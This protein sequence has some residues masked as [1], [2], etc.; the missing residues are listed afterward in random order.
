M[1]TCACPCT[2]QG[3]SRVKQNRASKRARAALSG[4][5]AAPK[6]ARTALSSAQAAPKQARTALSSA[7]ASPKRARGGNFERPGGAEQ[8]RAAI[9]S[10]PVA[11]VQEI[12]RF[13][14]RQ[15]ARMSGKAPGN[16]KTS[17]APARK[18]TYRY[19]YIYIYIYI[20]DQA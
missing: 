5:H 2:E 18:F 9:S 3:G 13:L 17:Q 19:I 16:S 12:P 15:R 20:I 8:A 4:A 11:P 10:A 14:E 6:Q 7:Q 1:R